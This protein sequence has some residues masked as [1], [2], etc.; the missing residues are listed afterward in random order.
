MSHDPNSPEHIAA[1]RKARRFWVSLIVTFLGLQVVIGFA[2]LRLATGDSSVAIVPDYHTTA[3][4]WDAERRKNTA[5]KR[6]GLDIA[7]KPSNVADERGNR[8]VEVQ[9][10]GDRDQAVS[11]LV[12]SAKV[13]H[14]TNAN[15]VQK[16]S[17][18]NRGGGLYLALVPMAQPGIWQFDLKVDGAEEPIVQPITVDVVQ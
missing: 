10:S 5:A 13:Y 7:I 18:Q 8:A 3:L 14:H 6:L 9:I 17:F 2:S 4:N 16:I 15:V 1:E 11:D 12:L